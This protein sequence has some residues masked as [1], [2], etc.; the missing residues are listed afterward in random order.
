ML[1]LF[2]ARLLLSYKRKLFGVPFAF[3]IDQITKKQTKGDVQRYGVG[4]SV[5]SVRSGRT[6]KAFRCCSTSLFL[7]L[8]I[9]TRVDKVSRF[10]TRKHYF[11]IPE[12][13]LEYVFIAY[14]CSSWDWDLHLRNF[15]RDT[16]IGIT[17]A[18]TNNKFT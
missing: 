6:W 4:S 11:T 3:R 18:L 7:L 9:G 13:K 17:P 8:P 2:L 15:Q 14:Y 5:L 1:N 12:K 10:D 16:T